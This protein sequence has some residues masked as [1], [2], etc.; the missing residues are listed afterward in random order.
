M[1]SRVYHDINKIYHSFGQHCLSCRSGVAR[2]GQGPC[3]P[4]T[5]GKCFFCNELM[6]LRSLNLK[7]PG[8]ELRESDC[9]LPGGSG[10]I[11]PLPPPPANLAGF[12]GDHGKFLVL[13]PPP[14]EGDICRVPPPKQ[15]SWL[16]RCPAVDPET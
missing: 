14:T 10:N 1:T 13:P 12:R 15:K 9:C 11:F 6:L 4:Q 8:M 2:G 5:F 7:C 16:R 3:P